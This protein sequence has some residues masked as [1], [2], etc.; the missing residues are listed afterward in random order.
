[1][2]ALAAEIEKAGGTALVIEADITD[3]AQA[4]SAVDQTVERFGRLDILVNS[5]AA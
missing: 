3:H 1:M 4:Q 2:Q 5:L